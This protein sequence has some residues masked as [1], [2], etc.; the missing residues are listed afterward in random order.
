MIVY[1][2]MKILVAFLLLL[3]SASV[4]I[5]DVRPDQTAKPKDVIKEIES[6]PVDIWSDGTRLS[7]TIIRPQGMKAADK[8]PAIILCHGW[9]GLRA[10]LNAAIA[11]LFARAGYVVLTFDY[12]GWGDSDS[13]LVIKGTMAKS[14]SGR[15][16]FESLLIPL[17]RLKTLST[18]LIFFREN[19]VWTTSG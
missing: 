1:L 16:P 10:H 15:V 17:T 13:R 7:G 11:P 2:R 18:A 3:V 12:R 5:A 9:G 4:G 14:P 19:Q 8:L 6:R